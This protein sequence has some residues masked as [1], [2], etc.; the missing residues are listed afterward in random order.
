MS[1]ENNYKIPITPEDAKKLKEMCDAAQQIQ[2]REPPK[3]ERCGEPLLSIIMKE[4]R[5]SKYNW[6]EL[7]ANVGGEYVLSEDPGEAHM[8]CPE[9]GYDLTEQFEFCT[10]DEFE[11]EKYDDPFKYGKIRRCCS[12]CT[13]YHANDAG[14]KGGICVEGGGFDEIGDPDKPLSGEMCN[15]FKMRPYLKNAWVDEDGVVT[16]CHP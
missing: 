12:Y 9:C 7:G 5:P 3:C 2:R 15:A 16:E 8:E 14:L 13:H 4:D 11:W 6:E 10:P 1:T